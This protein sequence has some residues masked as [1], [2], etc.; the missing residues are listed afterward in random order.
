MRTRW[1]LAASAASVLGAYLSGQP[2]RRLN[3]MIELL[4]AKQPVFGLYAPSNRR[5]PA[6]PGAPATPAT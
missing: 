2:A 6:R 5:P 1:I 3:P 4:E